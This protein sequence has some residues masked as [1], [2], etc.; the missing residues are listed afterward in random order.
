MRIPPFHS[1]EYRGIF[2]GREEKYSKKRKIFVDNRAG[3]WYTK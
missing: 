1:R 2:A 3:D